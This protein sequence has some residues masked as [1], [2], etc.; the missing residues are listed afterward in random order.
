MV[1]R[2]IHQ[3][4]LLGEIKLSIEKELSRFKKHIC[5]SFI[6]C[7]EC[8]EFHKDIARQNNC[9]ITKEGLDALFSYRAN[10]RR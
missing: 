9:I 3:A 7:L 10:K 1:S 4:L 2:Q 5:Q 8:I 6:F